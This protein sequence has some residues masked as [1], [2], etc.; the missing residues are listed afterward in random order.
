MICNDRQL[1][2]H[3]NEYGYDAEYGHGTGYPEMELGSEEYSC[4]CNGIG[5]DLLIWF[6]YQFE[7]LSELEDVE[8]ESIPNYF[9]TVGISA[10]CKCG[11]VNEI[12]S[13]ECA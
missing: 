1:I 3:V 12:G 5:F 4:G 9:D 2:I 7:Q 6:T 10:R 11:V 13:F 8:L